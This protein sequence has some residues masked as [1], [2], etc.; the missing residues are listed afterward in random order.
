MKLYG[1]PHVGTNMPTGTPHDRCLGTEP[2]VPHETPTIIGACL[3]G[4]AR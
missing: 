4:V 3:V 2:S 1:T